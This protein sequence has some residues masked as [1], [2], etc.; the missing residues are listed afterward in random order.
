L[1][2]ARPPGENAR[3]IGLAIALIVIGVVFGFFMPFGWIIGGVGLILA[4]LYF[5]GFG[6]RAARG[7]TPTQPGP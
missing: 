5:A 7:D 3:M 2:A 6:R 4:V 1:F